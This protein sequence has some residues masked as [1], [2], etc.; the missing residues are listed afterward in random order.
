M[1]NTDTIATTWKQQ[2]TNRSTMYGPRGPQ[3]IYLKVK[4]KVEHFL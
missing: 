2:H 4:V 3:G 1:K